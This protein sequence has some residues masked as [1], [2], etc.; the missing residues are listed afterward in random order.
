VKRQT[1]SLVLL[2]LI[3]AFAMTGCRS[4]GRA[5][6]RRLIRAESRAVQR[7]SVHSLERNA[8]LTL[9]RDA[10]RDSAT[11][12]KRLR[13]EVT[14]FRYTTRAEAQREMRSGI[15]R[16][17]HFTSHAGPGRPLSA[18]AAQAR[19]G[20]PHTPQVRMTARFPKGSAVKRNRVIG[21]ARG[22]GELTTAK[23][24]DSRVIRKA[25]PLK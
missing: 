7:R 4:A 17:T 24:A 19:Y 5:T 21:G 20:L 13:R 3:I 23:R 14:T 10:V 15:R 6:S 11:A 9:K 12:A 1:A 22:V 25:V 16:G 18:R 2:A 8:R